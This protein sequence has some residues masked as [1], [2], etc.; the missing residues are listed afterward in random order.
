VHSFL[1]V[2]TGFSPVKH[3]PFTATRTL[4]S[5]IDSVWMLSPSLTLLYTASH[6]TE[7]SGVLTRFEKSPTWIL[8][9]EWALSGCKAMTFH[10]TSEMLGY[11]CLIISHDIAEGKN[12]LFAIK[13]CIKKKKCESRYFFTH[14]L[15]SMEV[16]FTPQYYFSKYSSRCSISGR[17][18]DSRHRGKEECLSA[19]RESSQFLDRFC[20]SLITILTDLVW[21]QILWLSERAPQKWVENITLTNYFIA[22]W[23]EMSLILAGR[24]WRMKRRGGWLDKY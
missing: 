4:Y 22:L 7:N 20:R 19:C 11:L 3:I 17:E 2:V 14:S 8:H 9:C 23:I 5:L 10:L 21:L 18:V 6:I 13:N 1:C 16:I 15:H 12:F 24:P